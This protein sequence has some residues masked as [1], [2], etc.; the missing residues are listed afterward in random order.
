MINRAKRNFQKKISKLVLLSLS[1]LVLK[2]YKPLIIGVTGSLGKTTTTQFSAALLEKSL[3]VIQTEYDFATTLT[4]PL[5]LLRL[6]KPKKTKNIFWF[7][8][9]YIART[10]PRLL[11]KKK[12][13]QCF[14]L[15]LRSDVRAGQSMTELIRII[16]P[17]AGVITAIQ[18]V[19]LTYFKTVKQIVRAKRA[20]IESLSKQGL[21]L[22][23]YDDHLVRKMASHSQAEVLFYG[24][25]K[26]ADI[27]AS[28]VKLGPD[29]LSF[30]TNYRGKVI[31]IKAPWLIN[32]IY[33]Y[34]LLA[35]IVLAITYG[36]LSSKEISQAVKQLKPIIGRGN[37]VRGVKRTTLINDAFNATPQSVIAALDSLVAVFP[38][39][40]KIVVLGDMLQMEK[41]TA[42]G[43]RQVG[44]KVAQIKP[45]F[46]ITVGPNSRLIA[47]EAIRL[48]FPK[49]QVSRTSDFKEATTLLKKIIQGG[50]VILFKASHGIKLYKI[51][52][53]LKLR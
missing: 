34:P 24:L 12:Y 27:R 17:Q 32:R 46:L 52:E 5:T 39:E 23:N 15:E 47:Q 19:H 35:A 38:A 21:A 20:L 1:R 18:P 33:L 10:L 50:E 31:P 49:K 36:H 51:I 25:A 42:K 2:K 22:L 29:G 48:G 6:K 28:Q 37:P 44:Q 13:P 45:D 7:L 16:R 9:I 30:N 8:P 11:F 4:T 43:H 14:V 53:K 3:E 41:L 26:Q 40:K